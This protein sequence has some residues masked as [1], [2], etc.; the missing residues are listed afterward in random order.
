LFVLKIEL[1][2]DTIINFEATRN[3]K[4]D[5]PSTGNLSISS[6]S[7]SSIQSP[8]NIRNYWNRNKSEC[9]HEGKGCIESY[10]GK[11]EVTGKD[12]QSF[13]LLSFDKN[14]SS[15]RIVIYYNK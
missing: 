6:Y 8:I 10:V 12:K 4:D 5:D 14:T 3:H 7:L 1:R 13:E 2:N 11:L 9:C 15:C